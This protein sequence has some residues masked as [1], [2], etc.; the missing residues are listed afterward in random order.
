[1]KRFIFIPI[2]FIISIAVFAQ[3][4]LNTGLNIGYSSST[5]VGNDIPGKGLASVSSA[6]IG[7]YFRYCFNN[8]F[9]IQPEINFYT[10]GSRI[11]TIDNLYEYVYLDYLEIPVLFAVRFRHEKKLQ[12]I[13]YVGPAI[14]INTH[15][16]GSRGYL[17]DIKKFDGGII[18]GTGIEIWKLSFQIRYNYGL[19][20]FDDSSQRLDL[21]NS[22]LSVLV[23]FNFITKK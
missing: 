2:L 23:G 16:S 18:A 12:P 20:R 21:R 8:R 15:A 10:K 9:A 6:L 13:I 7:G 3:D 11:N 14:G 5:F 19:T 22:T 17:T 4:K 1:M